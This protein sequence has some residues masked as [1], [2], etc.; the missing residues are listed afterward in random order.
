MPLNN[1]EIVAISSPWKY[2][3]E[4][5]WLA[6]DAKKVEKIII[7]WTRR[8]LNK[9]F[10]DSKLK[11]WKN[12][13]SLDKFTRN[14]FE[15][16]ILTDP[17]FP[18]IW[19][20]IFDTVWN[21]P[22]EFTCITED[23][24]QATTVLIWQNM[25]W[26]EARQERRRWEKETVRSLAPYIS[27][28][29]TIVSLAKSMSEEWKTW[30]EE[31]KDI[32]WDDRDI[33]VM[34]W[35]SSA[36][37]L[38]T[39]TKNLIEK[40]NNKMK[41]KFFLSIA[42]S[43]KI[44]RSRFVW[45]LNKDTI[46][47]HEINESLTLELLWWLKNIL[48]FI[49]WILEWYTNSEELLWNFDTL[50]INQMQWILGE[51]WLD[52]DLV[53]QTHWWYADY[54]L[55]TWKCRNWT[56]WRLVWAMLRTWNNDQ[57]KWKALSSIIKNTI[58]KFWQTVE[59]YKATKWMLKRLKLNNVN[60]NYLIIIKQLNIILSWNWVLNFQTRLSRLMGKVNFASA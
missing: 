17:N 58:E 56:W 47:P 20:N 15:Y 39:E 24:R 54:R 9:L 40:L 48:A 52:K 60:S 28:Q 37:S 10:K 11:D 12:I 49:Y 18:D 42:S 16:W 35:P 6:F 45:I 44:I 31:L 3:I 55:T 13:D 21:I 38:A 2:A 1:K 4:M 57:L 33:V 29:A 14:D 5:S 41:N 22:I 50:V 32:F 7:Y 46:S 8:Q 36:H 19:R 23:L 25:A 59:W 34:A 53:T 26:I 27:D 43:N 51:L 30:S